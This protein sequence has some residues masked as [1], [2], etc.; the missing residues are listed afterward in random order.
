MVRSTASTN[1]ARACFLA[2]F[3]ESCNVSEACRQAGIPRRTVY[4]WRDADAAFAEAWS[5]AEEA[6]ADKLVQVA[7]DRALAGESDRMLEILLKGHRPKYRDKQAIE[8]TGKDGGPI[9]HKAAAAAEIADIFG[10]TPHLIE[11]QRDG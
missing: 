6:A 8:V 3:A 7:W 2:V 5:E 1:R 9:E 10:P 11:T 4:G